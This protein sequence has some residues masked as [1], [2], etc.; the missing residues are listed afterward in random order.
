M[1][2]KNLTVTKSYALNKFVYKNINVLGLKIMSL[3]LS[4]I[5]PRTPASEIDKTV[6]MP[7][8]DVKELMGIEKINNGSLDK[9]LVSIGSNFVLRPKGNGVEA[10]YVFDRVYINYDKKSIDITIKDEAI[11]YLYNL[12]H[13]YF[14][15]KLWNVLQLDSVNQ[16]RMYEV[17]KQY[18]LVGRVSIPLDDLKEL[19]AI[20]KNEYELFKNFRIRVLDACQ[21]A[22][23]ENTDIKFEY[24]LIKG[25]RGKVQEILFTITENKDYTIHLEEFAEEIKNEKVKDL[26][27]LS[28]S[29]ASKDRIDSLQKGVFRQLKITEKQIESLVG[30]ADQLKT[31]RRY[32]PVDPSG[33]QGVWM[34]KYFTEKVRLMK[35][36]QAK[37]TQIQSVYGYIKSLVMNDIKEECE[38]KQTEAV[39]ESSPLN[40]EEIYLTK[41]VDNSE[42]NEEIEE[43]HDDIIDMFKDSG[44]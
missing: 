23:Q 13:S 14:K 24:E 22:L 35:F 6:S 31:V 41:Q 5:N 16:I 9:A 18:E 21:K 12:K 26:P 37:G 17:L 15:Y 1:K 39:V 43:L 32:H 10:E 28:D 20:D 38:K 29:S 30:L 19:L 34:N 36:Y 3:H 42:N 2:K 27:M 33:E 7:I 25:A 40:N 11:P 4:Q 8:E 44:I